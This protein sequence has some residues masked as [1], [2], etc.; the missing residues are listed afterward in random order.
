LDV[1]EAEVSS[2]HFELGT[3]MTVEMH[4]MR[5]ALSRVKALPTCKILH[6]ALKP[7]TGRHLSRRLSSTFV[8]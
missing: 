7:S 5:D 8:A 2:V 1:P 6:I 4:V 3:V